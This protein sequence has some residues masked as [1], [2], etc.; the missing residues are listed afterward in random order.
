MTFSDWGSL[1]SILGLLL[2]G[3][4][5]Y[6]IRRLRR[7]YTF[8]A[9]V[10]DLLEKLNEHRSTLSNYLG[11]VS[12]REAQVS[13]EFV[14]LEATL[15]SLKPKLPR[16]ERRSVK[17]LLKVLRMQGRVP[18]EQGIERTYLSVMRV[19]EEIEN[20]RRDLEWEQR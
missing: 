5:L 10:P 7:S 1:A 9:R 12:G 8:R 6:E 2:T 18:S 16:E 11:G 15:K 3:W 14:R 19:T 4:A 13:E 20:L 17:S